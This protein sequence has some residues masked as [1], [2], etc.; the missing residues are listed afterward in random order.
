MSHL[1]V[2]NLVA[3][4]I[5]INTFADV[6][7][8]ILRYKKNKKIIKMDIQKTSIIIIDDDADF[9]EAIT[10]FLEKMGITNIKTAHEFDTGRKLV[11]TLQ[12]DLVLLDIN[13]KHETLN[14]V[15]L[16]LVI[17]AIYPNTQIIF[18][19][20][21][22]HDDIFEEAKKAKPSAF[23]DKSLNALKVRQAIELALQA[24]SDTDDDGQIPFK[25]NLVDEFIFVKIGTSFRRINIEDIDYIMYAERYANVIMGDKSIPLSTSMKELIKNLPVNK[26]IQIHKSYV[27]NISKI[28]QI[29]IIQN[30]IEI[31][32]KKLP[33]G[34]RYKKYVQDRFVLLN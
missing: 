27:V 3:I 22:Y 16:G 28:I 14:G 32:S 12:P 15:D 26:F 25:Y 2:Y 31:S 11:E 17:K 4:I 23:L 10:F 34:I 30:H 8:Y 7:D 18:F 6:I 20:N 9:C 1:K 21:E 24:T 33:I 29:N 13:L 19:T 5:Q